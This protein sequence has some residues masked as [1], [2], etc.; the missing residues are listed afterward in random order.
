MSKPNTLKIDDVEYIRADSVKPTVALGPE[1]IV[2]TRSAGVHVGTIAERQGT[3][4]KLLNARRIWLWQGAFTLNAVAVNGVIRKDSRISVNVPE[5]I[6]TQ[7][8]EIIAV[9]KNVDLSSTETK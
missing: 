1:V 7:A 4:V 8:I 6:L 2:R 9:S 5:I 3:E